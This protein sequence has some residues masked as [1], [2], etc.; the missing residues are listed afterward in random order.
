MGFLINI[1]K[2]SNFSFIHSFLLTI[3]YLS[4]YLT[5]YVY[6]KDVFFLRAKSH[7]KIDLYIYFVIITS[8][9]FMIWNSFFHEFL[10]LGL[11]ISKDTTFFNDKFITFLGIS[12]AVVGWLFTVRSQLI[13]NMKNHSIQTIMNARL[14]DCYN[15]KFDRIYAI[16]ENE[17][18][19]TLENYEAFTSDHKSV[20]HYILN[21]YEFIAIGPRY[22]EFDEQIVKS[23][24]RSQILKTYITFEEVI[25]YSHQESL[26]Y[27]EHFIALHQRW[28][29]VIPF[30]DNET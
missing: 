21:Y 20:V 9:L 27:F 28:N 3:P 6:N 24:M 15:E 14:S 18:S 25:N 22:N 5:F 7:Q 23:M 2:M 12:L 16:L 10:F 29:Q 4:F 26:T 11:K 17:K 19:L 13:T 30:D 1:L 8:I